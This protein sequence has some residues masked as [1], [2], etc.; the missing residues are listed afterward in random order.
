MES[1]LQPKC[2]LLSFVCCWPSPLPP[3]SMLTWRGPGRNIKF[4]GGGGLDDRAA[5][6]TFNIEL[7][8]QGGCIAEVAI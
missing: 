4:Q 3:N 2:E 1:K 5:Q 8:G 7:G 6:N